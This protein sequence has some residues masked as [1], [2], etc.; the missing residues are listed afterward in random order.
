MLCSLLCKGSKGFSIENPLKVCG[1]IGCFSFH[2][3]SF[4][5]GVPTHASLNYCGGEKI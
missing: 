5:C 2:A 3:F 1:G 4:C